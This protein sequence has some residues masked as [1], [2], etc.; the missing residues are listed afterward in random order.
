MKA[1]PKRKEPVKYAILGPKNC[2]HIYGLQVLT[3]KKFADVVG[4]IL[5]GRHTLVR[6]RVPDQPSI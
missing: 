2:W 4:E 1:M 6:T 5:K 3:P